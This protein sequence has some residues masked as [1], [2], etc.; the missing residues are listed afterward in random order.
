MRFSHCE[1]R[2]SVAVLRHAT[3]RH[4]TSRDVGRKKEEFV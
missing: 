1:R 3:Y 4:A 2:C